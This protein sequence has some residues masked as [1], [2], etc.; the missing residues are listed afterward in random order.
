MQF[1]GWGRGPLKKLFAAVTY[2][3]VWVNF[4]GLETLLKTQLGLK[5]YNMV[6]NTP[7]EN[8]A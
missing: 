2:P 7:I 6:P 8:E 1:N 5:K 3:L 4:R